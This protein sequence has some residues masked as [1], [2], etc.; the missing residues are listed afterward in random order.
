[1]DSEGRRGAEE[2]GGI[3]W[4]TLAYKI[5]FEL[6]KY[7]QYHYRLPTPFPQGWPGAWY[8]YGGHLAILS[9]SHCLSSGFPHVLTE[10]TQSPLTLLTELWFPPVLP[11]AAEE[12]KEQKYVL[13]AHSQRVAL[14]GALGRWT[15]VSHANHTVANITVSTCSREKILSSDDIL[16]D[17][18]M[19]RTGANDYNSIVPKV[20]QEQCIE[21]ALTQLMV[22]IFCFSI[23]I[24]L[25]STTIQVWRAY[26]LKI[27]C[28]V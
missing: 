24:S 1:M 16:R 20:M 15:L 5:L 10:L 18:S 27:F 9:I 11:Q 17:I 26:L 6:G 21:E 8:F 13:A 2:L 25:E 19:R 4:I 7:F 3:E 14:L 12:T 28:L 22:A 23:R